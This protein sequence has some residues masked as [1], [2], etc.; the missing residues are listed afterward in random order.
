MIIE[1]DLIHDIR[2]VALL[3][4]VADHINDEEYKKNAV[5]IAEEFPY[6]DTDAF[7]IS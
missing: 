3:V 5:R 2:F 1:H 6:E 7:C 4:Y